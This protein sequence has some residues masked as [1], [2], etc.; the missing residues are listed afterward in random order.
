MTSERGFEHDL[1]DLLADLYLGPAPDYRNDIV[2]HIA[3]TPQRRAWTFPERWLPMGVITLAR[4]ARAPLPWRTIGLLAV[5]T[6]LVASL[7]AVYIGTRPRLPAPFGPAANGLFAFE[8][9]GDIVVLDQATGVRTT[10]VGGP[11]ADSA[12][13]FSRAG[14]QLA[15]LR[16]GAPGAGASVWVSNVDGS[17]QRRVAESLDVL[18][19][20]GGAYFEASLAWSPDGRSLLVSTAG[21]VGH[22]ITIVPVDGTGPVRTLDVGMRAEGPIWRPPDGAEILFRGRT[23]T[24]Y[25]LFAVRPDGSNLRTIVPATA[26]GD[27]FD[28]LFYSWSPDGAQIAFQRIVPDGPR[29]INVV[30]ANGGAARAVTSGESV[31]GEWSPDGRSIAFLDASDPA[32]AIT[33]SVVASDGSGLRRLPGSTGGAYRWSPDGRKIL[34]RPDAGVF[35][36]LDPLGGSAQGVSLATPLLPDWQRLAP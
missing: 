14:S 5:L 33:V 25:G 6:L 12:P 28:L 11:T 16:G 35:V 20:E 31:G 32:G 27:E 10:I 26:T 17:A 3:R 22:A 7:V 4:Q 23:G 13:A 34:L 8:E 1:R 24:A 2:Q 15:F 21:D 36:L 9:E 29:V 30:D 18:P 19:F